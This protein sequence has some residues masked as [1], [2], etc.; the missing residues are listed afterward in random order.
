MF[1]AFP[2][3]RS[4]N[5]QIR[6]PVSVAMP[7]TITSTEAVRHLGDYLARIKYRHEHFILTKND[8]P[9]AELSPVS[10]GRTAT[11]AELRQ[12]LASLPP[13]PSFADDLERVNRLDQAP[14]NP[15]A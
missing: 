9:V 3:T 11:W 4:Q 1:A 5:A 13:D 14:A 2:E 15:W 10:H 8:Q 6:N 12:A 7:T